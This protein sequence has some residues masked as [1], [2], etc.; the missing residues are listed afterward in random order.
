M[1]TYELTM[2]YDNY[3]LPKGF[4]LY[5]KSNNICATWPEKEEYL[6]ALRAVPNWNEQKNWYLT[7]NNWDCCW[8]VT[9]HK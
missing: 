2:K 1:S 3:G 4:K 6:A 5:V 9:G 7:G 8:N